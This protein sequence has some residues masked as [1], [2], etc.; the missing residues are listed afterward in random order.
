MSKRTSELYIVLGALSMVNA[1]LGARLA[2]EFAIVR[3]SCCAARGDDPGG[4]EHGSCL[5]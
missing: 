5:W 3:G 2:S 1:R 4:P